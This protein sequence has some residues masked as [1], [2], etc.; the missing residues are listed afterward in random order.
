MQTNNAARGRRNL[1]LAHLVIERDYVG[2]EASRSRL[3]ARAG[4][5]CGLAEARTRTPADMDSLRCKQPST[6]R[7][8]AFREGDSCTLRVTPGTGASISAGI[9][10]KR[11][12]N[13]N[14]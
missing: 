14:S 2:A 1:T 7:Y 3:H 4:L 5:R 9:D 12:A 11:E 13:A 6:D 8:R 10:S